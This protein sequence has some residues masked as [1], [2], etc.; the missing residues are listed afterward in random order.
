MVGGINLRECGERFDRRML[1]VHRVQRGH[2][3]EQLGCIQLGVHVRSNKPLHV[4]WKVRA[5]L[6]ILD[7]FSGSL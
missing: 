3:G 7:R 6:S 2:P 1:G 4:H 5:Q